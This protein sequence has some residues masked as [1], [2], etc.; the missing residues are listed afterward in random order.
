MFRQ[1][2]YNPAQARLDALDRSLAIIEFSPDGVIL[3]ANGNFL[4]VV[5]YSRDEIVGR[6]HRIFCDPAYAAG[7]DY[8]AFWTKLRNGEFVAGEFLRLTKTG[9]RVWLEASYNPVKG[10]DGRIERVMKIGSD[11]TA[12]R[13]EV[14]R[15]M[16]MID[17]MPVAVMTADPQNDFKINYLNDTSRRTLETIEQYLPVKVK[18]LLGSSIDV[19]HKNP[20]HQREMLKDARH[21]PHRTKIRLGPEVLELR[22]S[23]IHGPDGAYVGPMLTWSIVT[24][25]SRMA[26]DV[27]QVVSALGGAVE[28]MQHSAEGLSRSAGDARHRASSVAA[29]S[30]QM[31]NSIREISGQV[32]R[33]S[34]R[35]RQIA[36]QAEATDATVRQLAEN[37]GKVDAVVGMIKSIASQTNLL[38]L[39]ATIEAAR[40]GAAGRGFAVVASE[41]KELAGQTARATDDITRQIADIQSSTGQAVE[42]IE[43]IASAVAELSNLTLAMASAVEEQSAAT[44]EMSGNISGVSTAAASTGELAESVRTIALDL[45]GH[46]SHLGGSVDRFLKAG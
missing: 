38:A 14:S 12:K 31:S 16:T 44:Q 10:P 11:I 18:D 36:V 1:K 34:E 33:V 46:S 19:F 43:T 9:H 28:R 27:S 42:A 20:G 13:N 30:E 39:N 17:D 25:Q 3:H 6:H 21:L 45:A 22:V 40:A 7:A 41:V 32:G 4:A 26:D 23:A 15:L 2:S 29:N 37:A 5:G 8:A 24:A 35:A